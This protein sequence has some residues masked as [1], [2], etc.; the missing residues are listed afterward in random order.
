MWYGVGR[1]QK[2]QTID[3]LRD[4]G[5]TDEEWQEYSESSKA[6]LLYDWVLNYIELGYEELD[7]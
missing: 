4:W 2:E 3:L 1:G 6:K 7:D 5:I